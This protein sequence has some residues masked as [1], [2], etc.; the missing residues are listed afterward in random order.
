[1][2]VEVAASATGVAVEG[3]AMELAV[4][5]TAWATGV[6]VEGMASATGGAVESRG[7]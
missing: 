6:A 2:A 7:R 1:M 5:G 4:K 3:L